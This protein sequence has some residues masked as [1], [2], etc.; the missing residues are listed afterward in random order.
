MLC[1]APDLS[2]SS[3]RVVPEAFS[4]RLE[5]VFASG[6]EYC[7]PPAKIER[8]PRNLELVF[9]YSPQ[10]FLRC[11]LRLVIDHKFAKPGA[12]AL[13]FVVGFRGNLGGSRQLRGNFS[14]V[15]LAILTSTQR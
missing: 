8:G 2:N 13:S 1:R 14:F 7:Y 3:L 6:I 15:R 4:Q 10:L 9:C 5:S 12:A 11:Q